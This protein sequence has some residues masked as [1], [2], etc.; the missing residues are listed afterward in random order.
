MKSVLLRLCGP[1]Q[2]WGTQGRFEIR[3]TDAEPSKSGVLGLVGA[4]LGMPRDDED[5]LARLVTLS[6]AVRVDREGTLLRDYHTAGGGKFC[7][8]DYHVYPLKTPVVTT[9]YYLADANFLVAL[10]SDDHQF[11]NQI[12]DALQAPRWPLFLGRRACVP[13]LPVYAG[14]VDAHPD[15]ALRQAPLIEP[16]LQSPHRYF[17]AEEKPRRLR[18]VVERDEGQPREDV[19]LSFAL[20]AR[21]HGRRTVQTEWVDVADLPMCEPERGAELAE[22][23]P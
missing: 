15:D 9:R 19:P 3:E 12:D 14:A 18:L 16:S 23:A 22:V 1:I 10:G 8:A 7:G 21:R 6:M 20:Y 5:T 2:S 17:L 13:S 4:A 11:I